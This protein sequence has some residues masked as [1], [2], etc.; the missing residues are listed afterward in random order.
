MK[1]LF[2]FPRV[3]FWVAY[4]EA[5]G[6][7][8]RTGDEARLDS[9]DSDASQSKVFVEATVD[10]DSVRVDVEARHALRFFSA[11]LQTPSDFLHFH[12]HYPVVTRASL[13][14]VSSLV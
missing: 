5:R 3:L 1:L 2:F 13:I 7:R 12:F 8:E 11:Q 4:S 9:L 14:E 6:D 10:S